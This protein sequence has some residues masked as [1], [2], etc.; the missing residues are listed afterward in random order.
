VWDAL[1]YTVVDLGLTV[2]HIL[3]CTAAEALMAFPV[4]TPKTLL[5]FESALNL[6]ATRLRLKVCFQ[7]NPSLHTLDKPLKS[8]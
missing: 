5:S 2:G 7:Q 4:I 8:G 6:A 1:M 3:T